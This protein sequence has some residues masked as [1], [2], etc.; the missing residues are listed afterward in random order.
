[1]PQDELSAEIR[2]KLLLSKTVLEMLMEG[3][4]RKCL[5][6]WLNWR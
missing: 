5:R 1:M 6:I 4:G 2:N 3:K